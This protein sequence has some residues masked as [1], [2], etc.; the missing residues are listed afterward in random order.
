MRTILRR[1]GAN[2]APPC[3]CSSMARAP[4]FQ[5]GYAVSITVT[6]SSDAGMR[7]ARSH[8]SCPLR[9]QSDLCS[10]P[11]GADLAVDAIGPRRMGGSDGEADGQ[12]GLAQLHPAHVVLA[13]LVDDGG[14]RLA[15]QLLVVAGLFIWFSPGRNA[16]R[17]AAKARTSEANPFVFKSAAVV[18]EVSFNTPNVWT[19][20]TAESL[21]LSYLRRAPFASPDTKSRS[22][23]R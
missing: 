5:A 14:V 3:G 13:R 20:L 16:A 21:E 19:R 15:L 10:D 22:W 18:G 2:M 6:R 9:A 1:P 4:A 11:G 7:W 17:A 8:R 23:S 12:I